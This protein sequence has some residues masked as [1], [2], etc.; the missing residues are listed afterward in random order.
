MRCEVPL[1]L[2]PLDKNAV[3][4]ALELKAQFDGRITVLSMGPPD[5][6]AIVR[7]CLALG[8]DRGILLS[9]LAFSGADT[10]AT[11]FTL[12]T[13][14]KKMGAVDVVLCGMAS[15]DGSTE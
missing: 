15:S 1:V 12:A 13:A 7:E 4:A 5:A 10:Y 8:A 2:N 6:E 3:E 11:A 9:D 14:I